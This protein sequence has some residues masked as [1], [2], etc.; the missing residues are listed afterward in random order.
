MLP[1]PPIPP[2]IRLSDDKASSVSFQFRLTLIRRNTGIAGM[3]EGSLPCAHQNPT[4]G[5]DV[6]AVLL[7]ATELSTGQI[8]SCAVRSGM[9]AEVGS[10]MTYYKKTGMTKEKKGLTEACFF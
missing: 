1:D 9:T 2:K 3:R 10:G 4:R 6:C 5:L 7:C 8:L